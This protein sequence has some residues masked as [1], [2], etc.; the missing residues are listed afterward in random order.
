MSAKHASAS[1]VDMS[2][3]SCLR[4]GVGDDVATGEAWCSKRTFPSPRVA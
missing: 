3:I 4:A 2:I 1:F